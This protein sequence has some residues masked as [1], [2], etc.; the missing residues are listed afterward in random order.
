MLTRILHYAM[1]GVGTA[2]IL[3]FVWFGQNAAA[4]LDPARTRSDK[5]TT[6]FTPN[7]RASDFIGTGWQSQKRQWAA[8]ALFVLV[9]I[10]FGIT[11]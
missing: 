5:L 7:R 10:L 1:A 9:M 4:Q 2:C 11:S 8:A 3:A 6:L